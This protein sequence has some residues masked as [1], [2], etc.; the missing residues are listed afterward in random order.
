M[1]RLLIPTGH[2]I[3]KWFHLAHR[4]QQGLTQQYMLYILITLLVMLIALMPVEEFYARLF[5]R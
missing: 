2:F 4:F 1:D 3:E 5:V